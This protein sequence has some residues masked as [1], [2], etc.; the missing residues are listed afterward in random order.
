MTPFQ[1]EAVARVDSGELR[2]GGGMEVLLSGEERL[3]GDEGPLSLAALSID[4]GQLGGGGAKGTTLLLC[5]Q[6]QVG[7]RP[8]ED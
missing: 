2:E 8:R 5:K 7:K 3:V 4:R 1:G 6:V